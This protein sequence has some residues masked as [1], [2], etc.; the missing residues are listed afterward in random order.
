MD[1]RAYAP[2]FERPTCEEVITNEGQTLK[3]FAHR[4]QKQRADQGLRRAY[5]GLMATAYCYP[6]GLHLCSQHRRSRHD[7]DHPIFYP[8]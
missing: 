3:G 2:A 1:S 8:R 5:C 6:C 4:G 7:G